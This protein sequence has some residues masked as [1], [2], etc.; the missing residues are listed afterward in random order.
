MMPTPSIRTNLKTTIIMPNWCCTNWTLRG[1]TE[2]IHKLADI[3]NS[4]PGREDVMPNGFG[5]FWLGNLAVALGYNYEEMENRGENMRGHLDSDDGAC[6]CLFLGQPSDDRFKPTDTA[7]GLSLLSFSTQSAWGMPDWL[8]EHFDNSGLEVGYKATDEFGNFHVH[9]NHDLMP[10]VYELECVDTDFFE[11]KKGQEEELVKKIEEATG[12]SFDHD[13]V[14][15]GDF[16][17]VL[18]AIIDYN[19][20]HE[21]H[22][23]YLC[24]YQDED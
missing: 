24:V 7:D 16:G 5:K 2:E 20:E 15:R 14:K 13:K 1:T 19:D 12:L 9:R 17:E 6:A 4:L 22:E 23:V 10:Y 11:Y 21:D 8:T 3:F 18:S